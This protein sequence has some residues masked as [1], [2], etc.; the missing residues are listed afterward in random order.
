MHQSTTFSTVLYRAGVALVALLLLAAVVPSGASAKEVE[1]K[2]TDSPAAFVPAKVTIKVGDKVEWVNSAQSLHSV[3]ADPANAQDKGDVV[4][5]PGAK[6]FDSGF[7]APGAKYSY[8]FTV[9]GTY[10]YVCLPHEKDGMK[11]EIV[12]E[13]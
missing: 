10:K 8:T 4:L 3:D 13:K 5:P 1:V 6:P 9:P 11:G 2:M 12:V 7:M